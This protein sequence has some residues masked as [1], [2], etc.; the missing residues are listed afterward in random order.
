MARM[1][2]EEQLDPDQ[3]FINVESKR[4]GNIWIKGFAGSGKSVLL[5]HALRDY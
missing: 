1:I 5:V 4:N 3:E 2:R